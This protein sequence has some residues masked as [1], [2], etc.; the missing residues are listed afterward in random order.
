MLAEPEDGRTTR[1]AVRTDTF[2]RARAELHGMAQY[3]DRGIR[4]RDERTIAPD[5]LGLGNL[6]HVGTLQ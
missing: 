6:A 4:P 1:R 2:E 3:M 5:P